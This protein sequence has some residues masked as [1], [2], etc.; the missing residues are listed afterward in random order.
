MSEKNSIE[1]VPIKLMYDE[2]YI[3]TEERGWEKRYYKRLFLIKGE[4]EKKE[5]SKNYLEGLEWVYKY[6]TKG[7]ED[8]EWRYKYNYAPLIKDVIMTK[9]EKR[10][11]KESEKRVIEASQLAYVLPKEHMYLLGKKGEEIKEKYK[12]LYPEDYE[13]TWAYCRYFWEAH[14]ILPEITIEMLKEM[15]IND[16]T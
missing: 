16:N 8:W 5:I 2:K 4:E 15:N 3:C 12:E 6:Y 14:P 10:E 9:V 1:N 7:C 11:K 13:F